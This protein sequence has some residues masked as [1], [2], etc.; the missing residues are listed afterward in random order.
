M[1]RISGLLFSRE[2]TVYGFVPE[3]EY[4][5]QLNLY[6]PKQAVKTYTGFK[7]NPYVWSLLFDFYLK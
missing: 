7:F 3:F 6:C 4:I 2:V 1:E 5:P